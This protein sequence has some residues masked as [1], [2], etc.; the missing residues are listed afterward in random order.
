MNMD[1]PAVTVPSELY[2]S[3]DPIT[4][5]K[6]T[7][8]DTGAQFDMVLNNGDYVLKQGGKTLTGKIYVKGS[9][10]LLVPSDGK[11]AMSGQD[12]IK[13]GPNGSLQLFADCPSAGMGGNGSFTGIFYAPSAAMAMNGSGNTSTNDFSGAGIVKTV[14]MTGSFNFHYDE[15]LKKIGLYR[16]YI[17]TSWN[18]K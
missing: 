2:S 6:Y 14:K 9:A 15:N 4:G 11:I 17:I 13:I 8:P 16:G 7:D 12:T 5:Q 18:E 1:F 3:N 10:R